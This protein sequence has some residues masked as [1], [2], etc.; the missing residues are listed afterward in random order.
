[1]SN[2]LDD[3]KIEE[4][5]KE[6]VSTT[7]ESLILLKTQYDELLKVEN[8]KDLKE[9][10]QLYS[11]LEKALT[12]YSKAVK[13]NYDTIIESFKRK[14]IKTESQVEKNDTKEQIQGVKIVYDYIQQ[15]DIEKLDLFVASL[16]INYKLWKPT[17]DKN[18]KDVILE[19]ENLNFEIQNLFAEAKKNKDVTKI[20][21]ARIKQQQLAGLNY[22]SKIGG[23]LRTN[24][25][26]DDVKFQNVDY[27]VPKALDA[28]SFINNLA[29]IDKKEE[30]KKYL[31]SD[32]LME[33]IFYAIRLTTDLIKYQPFMDGNKRTFRGLLNLMFKARNLPPI[34]IRKDEIDEYKK[35]LFKGII[36]EEYDDLY[37]FYMNKLCDSIYELDIEPYIK[38]KENENSQNKKPKL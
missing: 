12:L 19:K 29:S 13:P 26:Q 25:N 2:L 14:Y 3:S 36:K 38:A 18:N 8:K 37:F 23:V 11:L 6:F 33:Y 24:N 20:S 15:F 16:E 9:Y 7:F 1:M 5:T 31:E 4:Y 35:A 32:D 22:K 28:S 34:Y 27:N 30:F 17:D 21:E 10:K